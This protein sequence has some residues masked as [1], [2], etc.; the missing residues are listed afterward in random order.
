M[1]ETFVW[2]VCPLSQRS[3]HYRLNTTHP[4]T[5][6]GGR[7][8]HTVLPPCGLSE[9]CGGA[10]MPVLLLDT[11]AVLV[12]MQSC[13]LDPFVPPLT[14]A[15]TEFERVNAQGACLA[16]TLSVWTSV[17]LCDDQSSCTRVCNTPHSSAGWGQ[18]R[19]P[20]F[21]MCRFSCFF[22]FQAFLDSP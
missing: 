3:Q 1:D 18:Q 2:F 7:C 22:A 19:K 16:H 9:K 5:E 15:P 12:S 17:Y 8:S 4:C 6:T 10:G 11:K 14:V 20:S 21:Q 13:L